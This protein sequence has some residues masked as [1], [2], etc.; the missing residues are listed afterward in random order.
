[1]MEDGFVL[2]VEETQRLDYTLTVCQ[3]VRAL[4][5]IYLYLIPYE[6]G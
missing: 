2:I 1:M 3:E 4:R 6:R 5:N